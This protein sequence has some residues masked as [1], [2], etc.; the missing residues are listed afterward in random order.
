[1]DDSKIEKIITLQDYINGLSDTHQQ[2]MVSKYIT[3]ANVVF[4]NEFIEEAVKY[5]ANELC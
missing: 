2:F 1:M 4:S 3:G 5:V